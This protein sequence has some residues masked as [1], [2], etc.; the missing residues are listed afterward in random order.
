[1]SPKAIDAQTLEVANEVEA[2]AA[3]EAGIRSAVVG[4]D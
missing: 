2:G 4:V 3:V 1:M